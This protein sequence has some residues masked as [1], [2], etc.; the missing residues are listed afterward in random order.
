M[1]D[2]PWETVEVQLESVI[3]GTHSREAF[4]GFE[5][6][7]SAIGVASVLHAE[8]L[9]GPVW[10]PQRGGSFNTAKLG[11]RVLHAAHRMPIGC[12]R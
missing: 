11:V 10:R 5:M 2:G 7:S 3:D 8:S 9:N 12:S 1:V 6:L 4:D